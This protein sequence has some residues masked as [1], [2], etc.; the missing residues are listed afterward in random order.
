M[1]EVGPQDA[2]CGCVVEHH[3]MPPGQTAPWQQRTPK[4][5]LLA[6]FFPETRLN[7][8][9]KTVLWINAK[10]GRVFVLF[11]LQSS[12]KP[13]RVGITIAR[14]AHLEWK[15]A[16]GNFCYVISPQLSGGEHIG[17]FA[18]MFPQNAIAQTS[19]RRRGSWSRLTCFKAQL[20]SDFMPTEHVQL[21]WANSITYIVTKVGCTGV[22]ALYLS[23]FR[24]L[25][26]R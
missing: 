16:R 12:A 8:L 17:T 14:T 24:S 9:L 1:L 20:Q 11:V 23:R 2:A 18:R 10:M 5:Q 3:R 15:R 13:L 21:N 26:L 22:H 19:R 6:V 25:L 7:H 4:Y